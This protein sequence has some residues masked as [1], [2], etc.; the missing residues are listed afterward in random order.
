MIARA[1]FGE[2]A[3]LGQRGEG[4]QA[5]T[6]PVRLGDEVCGWVKRHQTSAAARRE[7][8]ALHVFRSVDGAG[9]NVVALRLQQGPWVVTEHA[10]GAVVGP[11]DVE[12]W[13]QLADWCRR[14]RALPVPHDP[15]P[16]E[17]ALMQRW[18]SAARRVGL[19]A[20]PAAAGLAAL[21]GYGRGWAHRDLRADHLRRDG[22][23][24]TV[25]DAGQARPDHRY[26]DAVAVA[27][28]HGVDAALALHPEG[29]DD[30]A[31]FA[32]RR[33]EALATWA[34][35]LRHDDARRVA[36]ARARWKA[37]G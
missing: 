12:A 32:A 14:L 10:R 4:E 20:P 34:W 21:A 18:A 1:A 7:V 33:L 17:T 26:A 2:A 37:I 9:V 5:A 25:I 35:G 23:H 6:W 27:A 31:W 36:S 22:G 29:L 3:R 11:E 13:H 16:L 8:D 15:L 24:L 19:D 28:A 30:V